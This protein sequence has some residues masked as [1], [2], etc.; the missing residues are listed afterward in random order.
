MKRS[1]LILVLIPYMIFARGADIL[2]LGL[3][4]TSA[5][6]VADEFGRNLRELLPTAENFKVYDERETELLR[7]KLHAEGH[8]TVS[9][10]LI[11]SLEAYCSDTTLVVWG[12]VQKLDIRPRRKL[13]VKGM[14]QDELAIKIIAY[15]L[16][17]EKYLIGGTLQVDTLLP[18]GFV[19]FHPV[20]QTIHIGGKEREQVTRQL[21]AEAAQYAS[22]LIVDVV[23]K[24]HRKDEYQPVIDTGPPPMDIFSI[25]VMEGEEVEEEELDTTSV[26]PDSLSGEDGALE[27]QAGDSSAVD[28][29]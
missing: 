5:P 21:G 6:A 11:K 3:T 9:E 23:K 25:E 28:Q 15:S 4:G 16:L 27:E 7:G 22:Q 29:P 14:I 26:G 12:R 20:D 8:A 24:K 18:R 19:F 1:A 13:L 17:E 2:Y 10:V